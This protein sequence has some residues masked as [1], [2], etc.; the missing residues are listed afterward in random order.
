[1]AHS[2]SPWRHGARPDS[3]GAFPVPGLASG[4][5]SAPSAPDSG[6]PSPLAS[7]PGSGAPSFGAS[8]SGMPSR[9]RVVRALSVGGAALAGAIVAG[10]GRGSSPGGGSTGGAAPVGPSSGQPSAVPPATGSVVPGSPGTGPAPLPEPSGVATGLP[11]PKITEPVAGQ[12]LRVVGFEFVRAE[13]S[14]VVVQ[15]TSGVPPCDAVTGADVVETSGRVVLTLWTGPQDGATGC[16]GPQ[17]AIGII[18]WIRVKLAAP[19]G[20]R[21]LVPGHQA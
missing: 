4:M 13:G 10:C 17:A 14:S 18:Q 2:P 12:R 21:E 20:S 19:L 5:P 7:Q 8:L 16:D 3:P 15:A 1:M 11:T 6:M 9:R